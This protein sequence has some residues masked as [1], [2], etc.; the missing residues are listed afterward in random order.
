MNTTKKGPS[1]IH[2]NF[3]CKSS[4]IYQNG[5]SP[6]VF[7]VIYRGERKDVFT[8]ICCPANMWMKEERTV[9]LRYPLR[10]EINYKLHKILSNVKQ[11]QYRF[12]FIYCW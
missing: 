5:E 11:N 10:K 3:M 8:G 7:R 6:I 9:N 4:R 12:R 2:F 1:E